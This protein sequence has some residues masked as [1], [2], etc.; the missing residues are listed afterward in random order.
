MSGCSFYYKLL[1]PFC[2]KRA[3]PIAIGTAESPHI[4]LKKRHATPPSSMR[5]TM[6]EAMASFDPDPPQTAMEASTPDLAYEP[7]QERRD[8]FFSRLSRWAKKGE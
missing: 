2:N 5:M 8:K 7:D 1:R 6:M 3:V 4:L